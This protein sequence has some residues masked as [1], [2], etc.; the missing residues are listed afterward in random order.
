MIKKGDKVIVDLDIYDKV[1]EFGNHNE[2]ISRT[3][4][5]MTAIVIEYNYKRGY[6]IIK[7]EDEFLCGI[8]ELALIKK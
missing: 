1:K 3:K 8:Y 5:G 2:I 4:N 6:A 7:F